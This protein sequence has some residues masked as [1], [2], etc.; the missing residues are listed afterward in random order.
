MDENDRA[1]QPSLTPADWARID[2]LFDAA[3]RLPPGERDAWLAVHCADAPA[4]R[5]E[6][7]RLLRADAGT[8]DGLVDR[9]AG[10]VLLPTGDPLLGTVLGAWRVVERIASGGMGVVYRAERCDGRFEQ[11]VALKVLRADADDRRLA[12]HF[13]FERRTL[14]DLDHPG[15]ARILD[16]GETAGGRPYLAMELV[17]GASIDRYCAERQLGLTERIRLLIEV[18]RAV[19]HAHR[20]LVVHRDLK[21]GNVLVDEAGRARLVD[22]GI[23]RLVE[24]ASAAPSQPTLVQIATPEYASPAHL[25][26][27]PP[28][29]ADDVYSLGVVAFELLAEQRPLQAE[30]TDPITWLRRV[31]EERPR[32]MS[33]LVEARAP[34]LAR[35]LRGDLDRIVAMALRKEAERRYASAGAFADD[36]ERHLDGRPVLARADSLAYL[37]RR[38]VARHRV[39]FTAAVVTLGALVFGLVAAWRGE[40]RAEDEARH[41]AV[42]AETAQELADFLVDRFLAQIEPG[43]T[44]QLAVRRDE[45]EAEVRRF[46]LQYADQPHQ[47]ANL[48]D[49]LGRVADRLGLDDLGLGLLEESL[50]ERR[51]AFGD[52]DVECSRSLAALGRF[53]HARGRYD[54]AAELLREGLAIQRAAPPGPHRDVSA[55]ANDLAACER[56]L[57]NVDAAIALLEE[58]LAL[59]TADAPRTLPVAETMNNLAAARSQQG[60]LAAAAEL[61]RGSHAIRAEILGPHH[62]LTVQS[63]ANR[64]VVVARLGRLEDAQA[65]L[66]E[67]EVGYRALKTSGL[68]GLA[69]VLHNRGYLLARAGRDEDARMALEEALAIREA[70]L[71]ADHPELRATLGELLGIAQRAGRGAEA[72]RLGARLEAGAVPIPDSAR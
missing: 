52:D 62:A 8:D 70:N 51:T 69:A 61:L 26:G 29:T 39:A 55:F 9:L 66:V 16:G 42:E 24:G 64:A 36:L 38:F 3:V 28:S 59:R 18:A 30:G 5:A 35:R 23:A 48:L 19:D 40:L 68:S 31:Q 72:A 13:E 47:R 56:P 2:E 57:G 67:A 22:F 15:I 53:H 49:A 46:R 11:E 20:R 33:A 6:V 4:L 43:D 45:L 21:P 34:K 44:E 63:V 25:A 65:L 1:G 41:A 58:A 37:G 17:R 50:A 32:P 27:E 71:P 14:A 12:R 54:L 10:G 60:D 7:E